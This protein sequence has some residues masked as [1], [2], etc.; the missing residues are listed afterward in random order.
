MKPEAPQPLFSVLIANYNNGCFL[1]DALKSIYNQT[2]QKWEVIIV[3]DGSTDNSREI[4]QKYAGDRRIRV[5][6]NTKNK[7]CGYTKRKCIEYAQ[8][9]ICGFVDPDDAILPEAIMLM[10][11]YHA[12]MPESSLIYATHYICDD[13]LKPLK[14]ADYVGQIPSGRHSMTLARPIISHFAT[15]KKDKYLLTKGICG[16]YAKA[17]DKDLYFKLEE[18]GPVSF[19]EKPLYYYRHH[20]GSISLGGEASTAYNYELTIKMIALLRKANKPLRSNFPHQDKELVQSAV[21]LALLCVKKKEYAKF[22]FFLLNAFR[23]SIPISAHILLQKIKS[24]I[25]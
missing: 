5:F 13:K 24:K 3:D 10:V 8:G 6:Y 11:E 17:V 21:G 19:I 18:T 25:N 14:V 7:G 4:Y 20:S 15:F 9:E 22:V 16:F 12:T 23:F 1:E 2:Y